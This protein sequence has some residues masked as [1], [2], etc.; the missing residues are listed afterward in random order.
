MY[1]QPWNVLNPHEESFL[2][3][4]VDL[5]GMQAMGLD[6]LRQL[7]EVVLYNHGMTSF[8]SLIIELN[9]EFDCKAVVSA[10][11]SGNPMLADLFSSTS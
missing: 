10:E 2:I 11:E 6:N 5:G 7:I 1:I 3:H 4:I 9:T 8:D